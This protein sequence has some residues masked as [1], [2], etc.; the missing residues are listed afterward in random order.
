M[1]SPDLDH[2]GRVDLG[3]RLYDYVR[4]PHV[5]ARRD[6]GPVKVADQHAAGSAVARFNARVANAITRIVGTMWTFYLFNGIA[7]VSLPE[8]IKTGSPQPIVNWMSSNWIQLVLLPALMVGQALQGRAA[9]ARSEQTFH[10][11]SATL[12]EA[13]Q[14]QQHLAAQDAALADLIDHVK[15]AVSAPPSKGT[16]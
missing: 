9:D 11:A 15:G 3:E 7:F 8:A 14:I 5:H 12:H 13:E 10:D 4:H 16:S 1:V 2:D 6:A